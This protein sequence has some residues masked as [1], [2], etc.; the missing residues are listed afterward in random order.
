VARRRTGF[1]A[2]G[3]SLSLCLFLALS[4]F[5]PQRFSTHGHRSAAKG[6]STTASRSDIRLI[7]YLASSALRLVR[8][9][10]L[11][12]YFSI[13]LLPPTLIASPLPGP[14]QDGRP[15]VY[16]ATAEVADGI[17]QGLKHFGLY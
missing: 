16:R 1:I 7:Q 15:R 14:Q 11:I 17:M 10:R 8:R 3:A 2:G 9:W 6:S 5:H 4:P 12:G 13:H